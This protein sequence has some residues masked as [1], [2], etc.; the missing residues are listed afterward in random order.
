MRDRFEIVMNTDTARADFLS[1]YNGFARRNGKLPPL[2]PQRLNEYLPHADVFMLYWED[3][4]TCGRLVL[5]DEE[6]RTALMMYSGTR[7]LEHGAHTKTVG[8]L[9]RYLHWHEIKTYRAA[10]ME[11]YNFG[12]VGP[13]TPSIND[14]KMSFGAQLRPTSL[15]LYAGSGRPFWKVVHSLYTRWTSTSLRRSTWARRASNRQE[16][17]CSGGK[18]GAE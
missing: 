10:G 3:Q 15:Y 16:H 13:R 18:R 9:N 7:R 12:G 5:R 6:S 2:K 17:P 1:L 8:L 11:E 14:F 4:P